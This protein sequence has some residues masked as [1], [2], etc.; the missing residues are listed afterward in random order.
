MCKDVGSILWIQI[1]INNNAALN[2]I[3][4]HDISP[5]CIISFDSAWKQQLLPNT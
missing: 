3:L 1:F 2:A 5:I 4:L